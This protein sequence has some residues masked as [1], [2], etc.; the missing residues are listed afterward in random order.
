MV[1]SNANAKAKTKANATAKAKAM[2]AWSRWS[3]NSGE[4]HTAVGLYEQAVQSEQ[5]G[6][7]QTRVCFSSMTQC[8]VGHSSD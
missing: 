6:T 7:S 5:T 2:P 1:F 8:H 4:A 3:G